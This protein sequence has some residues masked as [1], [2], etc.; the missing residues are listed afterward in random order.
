[1][2]RGLSEEHQVGVSV[3]LYR[4]I[5][6]PLSVAFGFLYL[7]SHFL[8]L[9]QPGSDGDIQAGGGRTAF[10]GDSVLDVSFLQGI[11]PSGAS[12]DQGIFCLLAYF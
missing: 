11:L 2:V 8:Q 12:Q 5:R 6:S 3:S 9:W 4:G 10:W 7:T 1:M